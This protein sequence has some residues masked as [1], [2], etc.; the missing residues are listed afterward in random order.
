MSEA[1]VKSK[2]ALVKEQ[3][4]IRKELKKTVARR[5]AVERS[6]I[7]SIGVAM[8]L[9]LLGIF[10]GAPFV[11]ILLGIFALTLPAA[12]VALF[13]ISK[14]TVAATEPLVD[15]L[16]ELI[17]EQRKLDEISPVGLARRKQQI[18]DVIKAHKDEIKRLEDQRREVELQLESYQPPYRK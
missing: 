1:L 4:E 17:Q 12:V 6:A 15:N 3:E 9:P 2:A 11:E 16:T 14:K 10:I 8:I 13:V 7:W 5:N 18:T